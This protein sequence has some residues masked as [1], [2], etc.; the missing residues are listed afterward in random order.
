MPMLRMH[1]QADR[2][3][4]FESMCPRLIAG[5]APKT[6]LTREKMLFGQILR[7]AYAPCFIGVLA[8]E[9]AKIRRESQRNAAFAK[10]PLAGFV[11]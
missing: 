11:E 7:K 3:R 4:S 1:G 8:R 9:G 5:F 6:G 2:G 10:K